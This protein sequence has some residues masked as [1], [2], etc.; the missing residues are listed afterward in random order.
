MSKNKAYVFKPKKSY[1]WN[2]VTGII[3]LLPY[4]AYFL[5]LYIHNQDYNDKGFTIIHSPNEISLIIPLGFMSLFIF[6]G[7]V[8]L[9]GILIEKENKKGNIASLFVSLGSFILFSMIITNFWGSTIAFSKEEISSRHICDLSTKT[10][11][12]SDVASIQ[13][14]SKLDTAGRGAPGVKG[15]Y[16]L[17]FKDGNSINLWET[18][19]GIIKYYKEI[20]DIVE[21][22]KIK[23]YKETMT[24]K[25]RDYIKQNFSK[26]KEGAILEILD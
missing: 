4:P 10:Y 16:N 12:W 14:A 24:Q 26:E 9:K 18:S 7:V 25:T 22:N 8:A 23:I 11:N 2:M 6:I 13:V 3:C 5:D 1:I 21:K 20:K 15:T 17:R 19:N